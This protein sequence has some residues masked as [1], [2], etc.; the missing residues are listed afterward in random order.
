MD[1]GHFVR[2]DVDVH[3]S[4]SDRGEVDRQGALFGWFDPDTS[5]IALSWWNDDVCDGFVLQQ[6][7]DCTVAA[8]GRIRCSGDAAFY[9]TRTPLTTIVWKYGASTANGGDWTLYR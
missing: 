8:G 7:G 3:A 4:T 9:S 2:V 1:A 6:D 5:T